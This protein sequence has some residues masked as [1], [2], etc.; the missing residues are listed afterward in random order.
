MH[1]AGTAMTLDPHPSAPGW[2]EGLTELHESA[3]RDTPE[4]G[5][6]YRLADEVYEL[7]PEGSTEGSGPVLIGSKCGTGGQSAVW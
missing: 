6:A 2:Y 1:L 7:L 3:D 4:F 5:R